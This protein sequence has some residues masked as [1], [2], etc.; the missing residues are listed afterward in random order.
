MTLINKVVFHTYIL[1][2][3][4]SHAGYSNLYEWLVYNCEHTRK[5]AWTTNIYTKHI[6]SNR[7]AVTLL[8]DDSTWHVHSVRR[9]RS[10]HVALGNRWEPFSLQTFE[11]QTVPLW[12]IE[13]LRREAPSTRN[14]FDV[15][16]NQ[17]LPWKKFSK[18]IAIFWWAFRQ[19]HLVETILHA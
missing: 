17:I 8:R 15:E 19:N 7:R 6:P 1:N 14:T 10:W 3:S 2:N 5:T 9:S 12:T 18:Y 4:F 16:G 11:S 13:H